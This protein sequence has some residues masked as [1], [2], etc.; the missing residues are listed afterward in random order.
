VTQ[1]SG[2]TYCFIIKFSDM[3]MFQFEFTYP[4]GYSNPEV[5]VGVYSGTNSG[6]WTVNMM[7]EDSSGDK[8]NF[9]VR[10][11]YTT[12]TLTWALKRTRDADGSYYDF[13]SSFGDGNYR[14]AFC[15]V[16]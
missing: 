10:Y 1:G 6:F 12:Q 7:M 15:G 9:L 14:H 3:T 8:D 16:N 2:D 13:V 4:V 5:Q 11:Q